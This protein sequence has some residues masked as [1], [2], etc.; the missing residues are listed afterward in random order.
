MKDFN[1]DRVIFYGPHDMAVGYYRERVR[2]LLLSNE[3]FKI[4]SIND[5]IE[6][7]QCKLTV[8]DAPFLFKDD[9]LQALERS[10]V[11]AYGSACRYV[12]V[13][14]VSADFRTLYQQLEGQYIQQFWQLLSLCGAQERIGAGQ[15]ERLLMEEPYNIGFVLELPK[16]VQLFDREIA[17]AMRVQCRTAAELIIDRLATIHSGAEKFSIPASL[18]NTDV[19]DIMLDYL[20][21]EDANPNFME[22][23][24]RWPNNYVKQYHP[25]SEVV[26]TAKHRYAESTEEIFRDGSSIQYSMDVQIKMDMLPCKGATYSNGRLIHTFSGKWLEEYTDPATVLNNCIYIFDYLDRNGLITIA[27]HRHD[28]TGLMSIIGPKVLGEYRNSIKS[29]ISASLALMETLAYSRFLARHNVC[30]EEAIE[31]AYR[32][33]FSEEYGIEGF[34]ISLPSRNGTWLDRC[35]GIGPEIERAMKEYQSLRR[36]GRID[37][38][39][40]P[41]EQFKSFGDAKSFNDKK[42]A[43][44]G[45]EFERYAAPL[46]SDQSLLAYPSEMP[47]ADE[48]TFFDLMCKHDITRKAYKAFSRSKID[49]IEERGLVREDSSLGILAPTESAFTLYLVWRD[50]AI[51]TEHLSNGTIQVIEDLVS[52]GVLAYCDR[53]FTPDESNLLNYVF[54]DAETT[55]SLGLRNRYSHA[56]TVIDDPNAETIQRD[57]YAMLTLLLVITLKIND[58]LMAHTGKGGVKDFVDWPLT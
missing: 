33:Y 25:S 22:V 49:Y 16:F 55:N 15:I 18:T 46:F 8:E 23:L 31:W 40:F 14:L 7:Y 34:G 2:Q 27:A 32:S 10:A 5:A 53:L 56:D 36:R 12:N 11:V 17:S 20:R 52:R 39:Y 29:D 3:P 54:N 42:Y 38:E 37:S 21:Q 57:Y 26:I 44:A 24:T 30:L 1:A 48:K 4:T 58:E 35:K 6:A 9:E 19:D 41:Y 47:S 51:V 50:G 45:N 43:V 13:Q 28:D